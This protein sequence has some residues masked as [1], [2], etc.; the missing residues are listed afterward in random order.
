MYINYKIY[1]NT[2]KYDNFVVSGSIPLYNCIQM[3]VS[4]NG[5]TP[6]RAPV[7]KR[8]FHKL[9][10]PAIKGISHGLEAPIYSHIL[11]ENIAN[12]RYPAKNKLF[13]G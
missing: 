5:G 10:Q 4:I 1:Q 2:V 8:I 6:F 11:T 7:Q 13:A 12:L 9:N 3:M